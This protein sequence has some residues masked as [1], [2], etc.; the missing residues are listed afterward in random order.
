MLSTKD[1]SIGQLAALLIGV[2]YL[3][4]GVVGMFFTGF[5]GFVS[6]SGT[7]LFGIFAINPFHNVVHIGVGALLIAAST[8][9][10]SI[11]E[12]ALL[13]VGSIY[14]VATITGFI[15]AHIPV[16]ALVT[17]SDPDNYLHLVTGATA[18]LAAV[19]SAGGTQRRL[20]AT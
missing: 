17:S 2:A 7:D 19:I 5:S 4:G 10:S 3:G 6:S 18:I 11:A 20:A 15:Y 1:K 13:G 9:P 14:V 16:I 8:A 12:G